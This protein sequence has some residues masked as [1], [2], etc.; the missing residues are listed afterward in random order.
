MR[1]S[2]YRFP[3]ECGRYQNKD[4]VLQYV[5][6]KVMGN[7]IHYVML[8]SNKLMV[9]KK[10]ELFLE[11]N[12]YFQ[13]LDLN[14]LFDYIITMKIENIIEKSSNYLMKILKIYDQESINIGQK[15]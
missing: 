11:I 2:A 5:I 4:R 1:I 9:E 3:I 8:Y 6:K 10:E 12:I 7:G 13:E 15:L 14:S